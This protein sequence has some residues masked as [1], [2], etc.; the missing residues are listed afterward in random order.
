MYKTY[1]YAHALWAVRD[2]EPMLTRPVRTVLYA[3]LLKHGE[4]RGLR[5][6][7]AGGSADHMHLLI[8]LHAAQNLAQVVRQLKAESAEWLNATKLLP[9]AFEWEESYAAWS[10][11]PTVLRQV[12][13]YF[14]RQEEYHRT[15]TLDQEMEQFDRLQ[16][17]Q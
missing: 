4:E 16:S 5:V 15:K 2:R 7:H 12:M 1:L 13:D 11:S 17:G 3:H 9:K 8:H 10:V 6:M 14:D